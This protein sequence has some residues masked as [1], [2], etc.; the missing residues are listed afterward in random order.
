MARYGRIIHKGRYSNT[1]YIKFENV[2]ARRDF[3][4]QFEEYHADHDHDGAEP[5]FEEIN[6]K[7]ATSIDIAT[8]REWGDKYV[9]IDGYQAREILKYHQWDGVDRLGGNPRYRP[10]T[11]CI[12]P[13]I[14]LEPENL[15][16]DG[17]FVDS[18]TLERHELSS[19][20]GDIEDFENFLKSV[21]TDGW[22]LWR[23]CHQCR[24]SRL[25]ALSL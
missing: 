17:P 14:V 23:Y 22:C 9:S 2:A 1:N 24:R 19:A 8:A 25:V 20:F 4:K 16:G 5:V 21:E 18:G 10:P 12:S 3:A 7:D 11:C 6:T 13:L 15:G